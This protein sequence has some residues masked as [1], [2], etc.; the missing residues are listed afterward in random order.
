VLAREL[1]GSSDFYES[2]WQRRNTVGDKPALVVW[3]M[4]DPAFPESH[5]EKWERFFTHARVVRLPEVGHFVP[6]EAAG[7]VGPLVEEF[8][9]SG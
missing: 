6:E 9:A 7:I 4:K 8:L 5:L 2:L 3:G 1:A